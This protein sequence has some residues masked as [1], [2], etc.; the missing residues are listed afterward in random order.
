MIVDE[1]HQL[2]AIGNV[3]PLF[4]IGTAAFLLNI[5]LSRLI[6]TQR[7]EIAALKAF[8]YTDSAIGAHYLGFAAAAV[9]LG[10]VLG[11]IG[12][13]WLGARYTG[14]YASVFRFPTLAY[15]TDW[16]ATTVA[17]AV[18]G[19]AAILGALG[20]VMRAVRVPPAEALRP[21]SPARYRPLL[22]ERLGL[23]ARI[24]TSAR[25]VLRTLERRP[26]RTMASIV[27]VGLAGALMV[28]WRWLG[29]GALGQ[30]LRGVAGAVVRSV[31][32]HF[33]F[34]RSELQS[35]ENPALIVAAEPDDWLELMHVA[36][37]E[38]GARA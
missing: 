35:T 15:R 25:M 38:S 24:P 9:V 31:R 6:A 28:G 18:S 23:G 1:L 16:V 14:L 34:A 10:A 3:F 29:H 21:E 20:A 12:G 27:G 30:A 8:G 13:T 33:G 4:F 26:W 32:R 19:G 36:N 37:D 17:I 5:V 7:D 11:V 2:S 22:L